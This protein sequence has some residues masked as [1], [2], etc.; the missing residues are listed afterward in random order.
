[1]RTQSIEVSDSYSAYEGALFA[2]ILD[3]LTTEIFTSV[4]KVLFQQVT[5]LF[6]L[7]FQNDSCVLLQGA[8]A[9]TA[10][11]SYKRMMQ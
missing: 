1:M 5:N 8:P 7:M 4:K 9:R 11:Y 3:C 6:I 10:A 2:R